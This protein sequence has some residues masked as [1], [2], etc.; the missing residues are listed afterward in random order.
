MTGPTNPAIAFPQRF[1]VLRQIG[2][3]GMGV[4]FEAMDMERDIRVALKTVSRASAW[5]QCLQRKG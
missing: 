1:S 4:V 3:G 2:A 5:W